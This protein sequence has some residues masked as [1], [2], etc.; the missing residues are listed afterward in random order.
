MRSAWFEWVSKTRKKMSRGTKEPVSHR[1]AMKQASLTW[2]AQKAK[3]VKKANR[4]KK[5]L[6][7]AES[8]K[9]KDVAPEPIVCKKT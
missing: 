6:A 3:L 9:K 1:D 2:A 5:K 7:K 4:E 8:S